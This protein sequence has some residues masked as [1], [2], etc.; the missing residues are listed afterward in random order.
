MKARG[1]MAA[2][3]GFCLD[4]GRAAMGRLFV[5]VSLIVSTV[6]LSACANTVRGVRNDI[7]ATGKAAT[8]R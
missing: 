5:V 6:A 2:P 7:N 1:A 4:Q 3:R 8:G